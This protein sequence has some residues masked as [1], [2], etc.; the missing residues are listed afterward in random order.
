MSLSNAIVRSL[1]IGLSDM[2]WG[3]GAIDEKTR[4]VCRGYRWRTRVEKGMDMAWI[5]HCSCIERCNVVVEYR[6]Y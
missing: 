3:S 1:L 4:S 6:R 5:R 2:L